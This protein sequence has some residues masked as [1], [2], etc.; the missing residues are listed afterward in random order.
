[1]LLVILVLLS[2]VGPLT[3]NILVPSLPGMVESLNTSKESVQLTL[4]LFLL[5]MGMAQLVLGPL[6]DRFGRRPVLIV[7]LCV[8]IVASIASA[9]APDVE[10]LIIARILQSFGATAG[11]T[12]GRTMIGD[13]YTR[14]Q[15]AS[16]IGY[17]TMAMVI[18]PMLSPLLGATIDEAFGWRAIL[19]FCAL[20]GAASL[21]LAAISLPET[22]PQSLKA[23]TAS[24]VI[25]R[26]LS[27]IKNTRFL[28]YWGSS[29]FCSGM[30]FA[31]LGTAPYLMIEVMGQGKTD[32]GLWFIILSF[33]YMIG[34]FLS[35]RLAPRLGNIRLILIGAV[36]GLAGAVAMLGIATTMVITP[37]LL[38]LPLTLTSFANGL[39][40]PNA[41][42]GGIT[43]DAKAAGAAS[44]LMGFGQMGLG[45]AISYI[46]AKITHLS[47][48]PMAIVMV[49][50]AS[51]SLIASL[52][53]WSRETK[54]SAANQG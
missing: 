17:V 37:F 39:I 3:L 51:L 33:G 28:A 23:A 49:I 7:A 27:L 41:T 1:M 13:L 50:C 43:V 48:V 14:D 18:A 54:K 36:I 8:F 5:G 29:A 12:L 4:S 25:A 47:P 21:T 15:A 53:I 11:I 38:F 32:Y 2:M 45:A 26:T 42:A 24:D 10:T 30:Y 20:F 22:R 34:N 31:F 9:F 19:L 52:V 46:T 6:A 40:L 44:G 35:G 16:R